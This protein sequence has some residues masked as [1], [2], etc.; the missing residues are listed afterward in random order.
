MF[1]C[2]IAAL[3]LVQTT[4][5]LDVVQDILDMT[6]TLKVTMARTNNTN[7]AILNSISVIESG[8]SDI[9]LDIDH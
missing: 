1:I 9:Y 3:I 4:L 5:R 2:P 8:V 6:N 7:K